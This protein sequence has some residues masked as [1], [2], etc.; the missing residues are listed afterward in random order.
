[1]L[2]GSDRPVASG[3]AVGLYNSIPELIERIRAFLRCRYKRI[4]IK[5]CPGWDIEPIEAVRSEFPGIPL[6]ADANASYG[7]ADLGLIRELDRFGLMMI[8]QPFAREDLELS[9][10]AQRSM[11]TPI[12]ADE[13]ADSL[14]SVRRI[15]ALGA[16]R[17]INIKIQR[18]GGLH[19]AR[20][21]H[22]LAAS[23]GMP[24]WVGTM[25]ELGIASAHGLHLATLPNF[26]LPSDI[27]ASSRWYTDEIVRPRIE[28]C[29]DGCIRLPAGPGIGYA[30]DFHRFVFESAEF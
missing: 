28:V 24:C 9:A 20:A 13:L 11:R 22:D 21:I 23:V 4:K 27:E 12:C 19:R 10:K 6:M 8:E 30:P 16:A 14:D 29:S 17:I 7:A 3:L 1:L 5:I 25:P 15:I 18:V 2:G 26:S